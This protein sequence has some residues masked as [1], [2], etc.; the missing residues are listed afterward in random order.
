MEGKGER[1]FI[2][3]VQ[4]KIEGQE[5]YNRVRK[6]YSALC[7]SVTA[8]QSRFGDEMRRA[9][10][11]GSGKGDHQTDGVPAPLITLSRKKNLAGKQHSQDCF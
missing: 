7:K 4:W 6:T 3:G 5:P 8:R 2:F 1:Q 11:K 10:G 9:K